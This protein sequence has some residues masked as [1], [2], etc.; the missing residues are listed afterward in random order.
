MGR[1]AVASFD[2]RTANN[3]IRKGGNENNGYKTPKVSENEKGQVA[4][5][6]VAQRGSALWTFTLR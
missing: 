6:F 5:L 2:I 1:F 4:I 3:K